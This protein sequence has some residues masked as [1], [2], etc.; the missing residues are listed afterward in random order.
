MSS[1]VNI[2]TSPFCDRVSFVP[3]PDLWMVPSLDREFVSAASRGDRCW[4]F[5]RLANRSPPSHVGLPAL[6]APAMRSYVNSY[7]AVPASTATGERV[8]L[9]HGSL[10]RDRVL[11]FAPLRAGEDWPG[12]RGVNQCYLVDDGDVVHSPEVSP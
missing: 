8:A 9:A 1:H 4:F 12:R 11:A 5:V 2:V 10:R 6:G 3:A 7:R